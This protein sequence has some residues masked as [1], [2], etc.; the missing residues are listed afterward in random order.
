MRV[1]A[2]YT[3]EIVFELPASDYQVETVVVQAQKQLL[4]KMLQVMFVLQRK[5]KLKTYQ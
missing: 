3:A 5:K 2:G 4:L 1:N